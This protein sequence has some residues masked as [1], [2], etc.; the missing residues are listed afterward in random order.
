MRPRERGVAKLLRFLDGP[1]FGPGCAFGREFFD[2]GQCDEAWFKR[3]I[4]PKLDAFTLAE[5]AKATRLS[6]AASSR[7]RACTTR[8][9]KIHRLSHKDPGDG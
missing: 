7:I 4:A 8:W 9:R 2:L 3:E 5:I 1:I 6:L